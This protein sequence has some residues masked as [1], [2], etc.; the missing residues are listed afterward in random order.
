MEKSNESYDN[1]NPNH[2][3]LFPIET[4]DMMINIWGV[5]KVISYCE[6]TA[7]KYKMRVG[8]KPTA[9]VDDDIKKAEW[10]LS[11]AEELKELCY[12]DIDYEEDEELEDI[13]DT[14]ET[15]GRGQDKKE[16]KKKK[17]LK[18]YEKREIENLF[19]NN[20]R[21]SIQSVAKRYDISERF[22]YRLRFLAKTK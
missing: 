14:E 1:V 22:A 11:K 13:E 21:L 20:P 3:K 15:S 7:F 17:F 6:I 19:R 9:S 18:D 8:S 12:C 4:I 10:Y 16:R 2:Y 5:D